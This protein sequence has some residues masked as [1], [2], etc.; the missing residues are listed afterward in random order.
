MFTSNTAALPPNTPSVN[1]S[2]VPTPHQLSNK[3]WHEEGQREE[4]DGKKGKRVKEKVS[5]NFCIHSSSLL[6]RKTMP[7]MKNSIFNKCKQENCK[8]HEKKLRF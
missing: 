6:Y 8:K 1:N 4:R 5:L 7:N 2:T 3:N